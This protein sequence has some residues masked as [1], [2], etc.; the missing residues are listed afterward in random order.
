MCTR[1]G[2]RFLPDFLQSLAVQTRQPDELVVGDDGSSD[3]TVELLE[4]FARS[5][6]F[7]VR[8][9][10]RALQLGVV[11]NFSQTLAEARADVVVPADQDDLWF[12]HRLE[13]IASA[14]ENEPAC[15][16]AL[17]D[18]IVIDR[19]GTA[20]GGSLWERLKFDA[21]ERSAFGDGRALN[22][23]LRHNVVTGATMALSRIVLDAALPIPDLGLHDV[24]FGF[25]SALLDAGAGRLVV[26]D[27]PLVKYRQHEAN[28][29]GA[30]TRSL[31]AK[32]RRRAALGDVSAREALQLRVLLTQ[33][34]TH[35]A[36]LRD[37]DC[38][39]IDAKV[40]FLGMRSTLA[41]VARW[42]RVPVL[43]RR[44]RDYRRFAQGAESALFDLVIR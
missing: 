44:A 8:I 6:P 25:A 40:A 22:I 20:V 14:F 43:L 23:L 41:E 19:S 12:A 33:L 39:L 30:P 5:A 3:G 9:T 38:A 11:A 10:T 15:L 28:L 31:R 27:E 35:G 37:Q 29:V 24:W 4:A 36:R 17:S 34:R 13:Q 26:L 2:A 21:D 42:R 18:A 1:D 16:V 7:P 32:L